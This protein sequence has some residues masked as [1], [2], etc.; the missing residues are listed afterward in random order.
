MAQR[1][2]IFDLD[3]LLKL[4]THYTMGRVP[5]TAEATSLDFSPA[6]NRYISMSVKSP[7][8]SDD[9]R[10]D[11]LTGELDLYHF[12]YEGRRTF[13]LGD[14]GDPGTWTQPGEIEAPKQ[15]S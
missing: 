9:I 2:V 14:L 12:R 11:P 6:L 1:L 8:W 3:S 7:E 4:L 15:T 5:L 13:N 10:V